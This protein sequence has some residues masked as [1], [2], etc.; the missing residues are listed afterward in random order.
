MYS[1][2]AV[3]V[4]VFPLQ[5]HAIIRSGHSILSLASCCFGF[6]CIF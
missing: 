3:S 4:A 1:T 2:L 6:N 5:A